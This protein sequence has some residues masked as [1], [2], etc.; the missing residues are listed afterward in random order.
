MRNFAIILIS[1]LIFSSCGSTK[2]ATVEIP[3][4]GWVLTKPV[5]NDYYIGIGTSRKIGTLEQYTEEARK[6]ALSSIA[7]EIS[8]KIS[9]VSVLNQ[10]E[11][12]NGISE[13]FQNKIK[14][15][16][17]DMLAGYEMVEQFEN[18]SHYWVYYKLS[19]AKYEEEKAKRKKAAIDNGGEKFL[20]AVEF[21][22]A[23]N[24]AEALSFYAQ[25]LERIIEYLGEET[26]FKANGF[27]GDLGSE[28]LTAISRIFDDISISHRMRSVSSKRGAAIQEDQLGFYVQTKG[29]KALK[30]IPVK[31][32][33]SG[34]YLRKSKTA[35]NNQ[36][37]VNTAI[38][39]IRSSKTL[40]I[41]EASIDKKE[42]V[43]KASKELLIRKIMEKNPVAKHS[44]RIQI[45]QPE[46]YIKSVEKNPGNNSLDIY[47]QVLLSELRKS[48]I[49]ITNQ[50]DN[51]D[52]TI[53]LSC[54]AEKAGRS[55]G[56][57]KAT[58]NATVQLENQNQE[59]LFSGQLDKDFAGQGGFD[60]AIKEVYG[61]NK[62]E[63]KRKLIT[64][65]IKLMK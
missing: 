51:A 13:I 14:A 23:L 60:K 48:N 62:N 49:K 17:K 40:E 20:K 35:S 38:D 22:K 46:V 16:S 10:F 15:S 58:L 59:V 41:L 18:E 47:R 50:P 1:I 29:R 64:P 7:G 42:L 36:G 31:F 25:S 45:E 5:I 24:Y 37:V 44:L 65:L 27:S 56:L 28:S 61:K 30:D 21:E 3:K 12:Q 11:D 39:K 55:N 2:K 32:E 34:G 19:K 43:R 26:P 57:Y 4:P 8:T 6:N 63:F 53:S 54:Q 33:F 9:S 52:F